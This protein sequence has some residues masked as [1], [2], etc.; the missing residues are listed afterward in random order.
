MTTHP[1][2]GKLALV[3]GGGPAPGING[4]ISSVT[5]AAINRGIEV[6]GFQ[7]GFKRL[8]NGETTHRVLSIDDVR[9][10]HNRGGSILGTSRTNP[11]KS[12]RDMNNVLEAFNKLGVTLL[13]TIVTRWA[14]LR[15]KVSR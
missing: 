2:G 14:S 15:R 4:V 13:A 10:I 11:T 8:V 12:D 6:I 5:I 9:F 7:D 3:V 1:S